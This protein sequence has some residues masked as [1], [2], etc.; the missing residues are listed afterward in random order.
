[1][2][3][4][5]IDNQYYCSQ[6][7]WWLTVEPERRSMLSCCAA[8]TE[9]IDLNWLKEN[10]GQLFNTPNLQQERQQMLE[11]NPVASCED[12]CWRAERIGLPSRRTRSGSTIKSHLDVV[13]SPTV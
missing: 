13:S 6:K 2:P 9:K 11:N 8:S 3:T 10:P 1:M 7:F 12:S 5:I 4:K